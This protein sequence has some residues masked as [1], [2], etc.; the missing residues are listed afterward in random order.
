MNKNGWPTSE[1]NKERARER[2]MTQEWKLNSNEISTFFKQAGEGSGAISFA[3]HI[4]GEPAQK[5][6]H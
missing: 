1:I 2:E 5:G 6:S 4:Y 3:L